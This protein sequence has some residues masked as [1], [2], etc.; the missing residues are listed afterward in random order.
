MTVRECC[1]DWKTSCRRQRRTAGPG[2]SP[3]CCHRA[4]RPG[5]RLPGVWGVHE[6]GQ[7]PACGAG[8]GLGRQRARGRARV[9]QAAPSMS[10]TT[11]LWSPTRGWSASSTPAPPARAGC[12]AW[13]QAAPGRHQ[14]HQ[15]GRLRLPQPRELP[16]TGTL[17]HRAHPSTTRRSM[18]RPPPRGKSESRLSCAPPFEWRTYAPG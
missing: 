6:P 2:C 14:E 18:T 8:Q 13:P 11:V 9:A 5:G 4:P 1:S 3:G 16:G 12:S 10:R 15:M 7:G 17:N